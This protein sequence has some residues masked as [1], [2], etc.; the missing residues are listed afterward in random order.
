MSHI[1]ASPGLVRRVGRAFTRTGPT[2]SRGTARLRRIHAGRTSVYRA[3]FAPTTRTPTLRRTII[4][5]RSVM[6]LRVMRAPTA[7]AAS[8]MVTTC[9]TSVTRNQMVGLTLAARSALRASRARMERTASTARKRR[10]ISA[11]APDIARNAPQGSSKRRVSPVT[12]R[13]SVTAVLRAPLVSRP[14]AAITAAR[15]PILYRH[16]AELATRARRASTSAAR[17]VKCFKLGAFPVRRVQVGL[18]V[19][20]ATPLTRASA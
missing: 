14:K 19:P 9:P 6:S 8:T 3:R 13:I 1:W 18:I 10:R 11:E 5:P 16:D 15:T 20:T 17:A 7:A 2:L 4:A 12:T